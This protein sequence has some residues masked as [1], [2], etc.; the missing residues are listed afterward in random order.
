[1]AKTRK[2]F[3]RELS[4]LSFNERVLQEAADPSVPLL[5]RIK[6]LG[7]FSNNLDEFFKVRVATIKRMI[8]VQEENRKV[9]GEKPKKLMTE[10][11]KKVILQQQKFEN[12]WE[13]ILEELK[14]ENIFIIN[15]QQLVPSQAEYVK[16]YFDDKVLPALSPVMLH[17]VENFPLLKDKSIYFAVKLT[18]VAI[19]PEYALVEIPSSSVSRFLVLPEEHGNKYIILLDDVIRFCLHDVFSIFHYTKIEAYTIKLTRDAELDLDNDLSQSL[20]EMISKGVSSRKSGQPVRFVYDK[21]IPSDLFNYVINRLGLDIDDNL[22][23]GGRYHNF[24]D[25]M[26]FPQIGGPHLIH[27]P[28]PPVDHQE[29]KT[30]ESILDLI[31]KKDILLHY[32]YQKFSHFINLLRE[33][34]IDPLVVSIKITLYRV[35]YTSRVVNALIN[36]ARNGKEVWVLFE[37]QARFDEKTNIYWTRKLEE[38]GV[39]VLFGIKGL[40]VHGKLLLISKYEHKKLK[41]YAGISTGNF[42]EGNASVYS[43]LTLLTRDRRITGEVYKAFEMFN[44]FYKN[45]S[46]KHL[47]LA[48]NFMRKR[49]IALIDREIKNVRIG[50]NAF[51]IVKVNN[52]VDQTMVKKL[53]QAANEGV[54]I[55][56]IVRGMCSIFTGSESISK[57]IE[58]ISIVDKY[59]E[60]S[61]IFIFCNNDKELYYISSADWMTRNLDHRV[62]VSC[63]IF[64]PEIKKEIRKIIDTQLQDN[65]KA[66]IISDEQNNPYKRTDNPRM[67]RSQIELYNYYLQKS[68]ESEKVESDL[69]FTK[70]QG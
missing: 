37:L 69:N 55:T 25:F 53:Y 20:L 16:E 12:I 34:A 59:L 42:H 67:V 68:L 50:R 24:K 47:L 35:A 38:A 60:H 32:P 31:D 48:P 64:D 62:E 2:I 70:I 13:Q 28:A 9:E 43:D 46:F 40:K 23:P 45:Y 36:A 39:N 21:D 51:I 66:R 1:M 29:I 22:I 65:V 54:K 26:S 27:P 8:D 41:H 15:E 63:P 17:N 4:W 7:I 56:L 5:E 18:G 58:A 6:F 10:I 33:A 44:A 49:L 3:S 11:Q 52:L 19:K 61:R 30:D 57:N 14:D